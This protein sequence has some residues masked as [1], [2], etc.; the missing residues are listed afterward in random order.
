VPDPKPEDRRRTV[1]LVGMMGSGKTTVGP[2]LAQRLGVGF[3]DLDDQVVGSIG[4]PIPEI[5]ETRGEAAFRAAE[6]EALEHLLQAPGRGESQVVAA[7]GGVVADPH[8]RELMNRCAT[9]VWLRTEVAML[10]E[11]IGAAEGRPLL[12]GGTRDCD[13]L[14]ERLALIET[15]R[16]ELYRS[17]ADIVVDTDGLSPE[18]VADAIAAAI[19]PGGSR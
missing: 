15:Q 14:V 5:F 10:A 9:V 17:S 6:S 16:G 8:N 2:L 13:H 12:T 19:D 11:R 7:G 3:A 18:S 4:M 1:L